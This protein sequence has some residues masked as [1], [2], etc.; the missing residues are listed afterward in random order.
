MMPET[1]GRTSATRVGATRP[2]NSRTIGRGVGVLFAAFW[3]FRVG[4][5]ITIRKDH[6]KLDTGLLWNLLKIAAPAILQFTVAT[7]SWSALVRV[8]A[9]FGSEA[10]AGYVI[11]VIIVAVPVV[12]AIMARSAGLLELA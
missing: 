9:G 2:G 10:I 12:F 4:G 8:V 5:R 7:A 1:R 3:L 6:W 11:G